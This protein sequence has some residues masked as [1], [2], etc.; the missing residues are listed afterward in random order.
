M[1]CSDY[2]ICF[3]NLNQFCSANLIDNCLRAAKLKRSGLSVDLIGLII[4]GILSKIWRKILSEILAK[5]L[6]KNP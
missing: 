1:P 6:A 5:N 3:T 4:D 2:A